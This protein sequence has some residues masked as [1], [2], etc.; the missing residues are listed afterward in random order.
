MTAIPVWGNFQRGR[1]RF[2][3]FRQ[4]VRRFVTVGI[5]GNLH[6]VKRKLAVRPKAAPT[7][8]ECLHFLGIV[9]SLG[10]VGLALVPD[11][12][13]QCKGD[14]GVDHGVV[15]HGGL[16]RAIWRQEFGGI[17]WHFRYRLFALS[18]RPGGIEP[19][20]DFVQYVS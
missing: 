13:A 16:L 11:G 1:L 4:Y 2:P 10:V 3:E 17:G 5:R 15:E 20:F 8:D 9:H 14:E 6:V 18:R 12:T 7:P 19:G